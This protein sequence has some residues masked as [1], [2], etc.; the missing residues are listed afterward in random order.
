MKKLPP[1][2]MPLPRKPASAAPTTSDVSG[3][4][5]QKP[6]PV[7]YTSRPKLSGRPPKDPI[8]RAAR[9]AAIAA[10][11][12]AELDEKADKSLDR[13][14]KKTEKIAAKLHLDLAEGISRR[15]TKIAASGAQ[16]ARNRCRI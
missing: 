2:K 12:A 10:K 1:L 8:L 15:P 5:H 9:D 7:D 16:R 4:A 14:A 3:V 11:K 13:E 6:A